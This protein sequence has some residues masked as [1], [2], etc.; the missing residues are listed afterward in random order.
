MTTPMP[1]NNRPRGPQAWWIQAAI[2]SISSTILSCVILASAGYPGEHWPMAAA[3]MVM[4]V[5]GASFCTEL[6]VLFA[7]R[8][9]FSYRDAVFTKH[10]LE[11]KQTE[12]T[13]A[14]RRSSAKAIAM[15]LF[16]SYPVAMWGTAIFAFQWTAQFSN[17]PPMNHAFYSGGLI[18]LMV[19]A[20]TIAA[21]IVFSFGMI[22]LVDRLWDPAKPIPQVIRW[23][24]T[25]A[26]FTGAAN[27]RPRPSVFFGPAEAA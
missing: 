22:A 3:T 1:K 26:K 2:L 16:L 11:W 15:V 5:F 6:V 24:Y 21:P 8:R 10:D 14:G 27:Q 20:S 12:A 4:T 7:S 17:L 25:A 13:T 19:G 18:A 9:M 23:I